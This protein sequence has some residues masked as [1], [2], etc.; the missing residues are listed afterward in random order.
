[1]IFATWISSSGR[2]MVAFSDEHAFWCDTLTGESFSITTV[3][4][5]TL[6]NTWKAEGRFIK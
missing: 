1:M 3:W 6:L 5:L 4:M 2:W